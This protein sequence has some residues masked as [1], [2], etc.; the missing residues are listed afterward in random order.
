MR[1]ERFISEIHSAINYWDQ[2]IEG[3]VAVERQ[4]FLWGQQRYLFS[5]QY[6]QNQAELYGPVMSGLDFQSA[7]AV[8]QTSIN[9]ALGGNLILADIEERARLVAAQTTRVDT[10]WSAGLNVEAMNGR[11]VVLQDDKQRWVKMV[12]LEGMMNVIEA[13]DYR[14]VE[15]PM[16]DSS[17]SMLLITPV[18]G[19]FDNLRSRLDESFLQAQLQKLAPTLTTVMVPHFEIVRELAQEEMPDLGVALSGSQS[20]TILLN[21]E[22]TPQFTV[23]VNDDGQLVFEVV[24]DG[25]EE[26][27][28]DNLANFSR[29]NNAGYLNLLP[30]R[31]RVGF[32]VRQGS[33]SGSSAGVIVHEATEN[34]PDWLLGSSSQLGG[35]FNSGVVITGV[36]SEISC[37]YPPDQRSFLY[38]VYARE[39]GTLLYLGHVVELSGTVVVADWRVSIFS[40]CGDSKPVKVYQYSGTLQCEYERGISLADMK[41]DL[42][43]TGIEVL[44]AYEGSDGLVRPQVCGAGTGN[45][46]VYSIYESDAPLAESL[47]F[48]RLSELPL[49]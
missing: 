4:R 13:E 46:N 22:G 47:D 43:N 19:E 25:T 6:L 38:A 49:D 5:P 42:I 21:E 1:I 18:L 33:I 7:P 32:T 28:S 27:N 37:Y 40:G 24:D 20:K 36:P 17:L 39:T 34:E 29:V 2:Q 41:A 31:Q 11:F 9:E 15:V 26:S 23:N 16:A 45:I 12:R 8:A 10:E 48:Q 35:G 3:L 44:E 14:A 30:P